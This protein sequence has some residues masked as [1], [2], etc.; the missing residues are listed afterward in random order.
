MG[1]SLRGNDE[2]WEMV[3][4][5]LMVWGG[6]DGVVGGHDGERVE[7][8]QEGTAG[9]Q[10]RRKR[11]DREHSSGSVGSQGRVTAQVYIGMGH[12][13]KSYLGVCRRD[14]S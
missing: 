2:C 10:S 8:G 14:P 12:H 11:K 6:V 5:G 9:R 4:D 13:V 3:W 7:E 1:F